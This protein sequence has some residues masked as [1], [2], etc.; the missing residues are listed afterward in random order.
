MKTKEQILEVIEQLSEHLEDAKRHE[1]MGRMEILQAAVSN[2]QLG[3]KSSA[4]MIAKSV[5]STRIRS[6]LE[7]L[8]DSLKWVVDEPSS[9]ELVLAEWDEIDKNKSSCD[10]CDA[11][12]DCGIIKG[13]EVIH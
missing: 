5:E 11:R 9:L 8:V 10:T 4:K 13:K 2:K 12:S 3:S 1:S 6:L 7:G